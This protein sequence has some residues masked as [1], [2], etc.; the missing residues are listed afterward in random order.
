LRDLLNPEKRLKGEEK[1]NKNKTDKKV[2]KW[3]KKWI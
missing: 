3:M 1:L 2:D